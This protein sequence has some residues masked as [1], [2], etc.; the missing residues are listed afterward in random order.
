MKKVTFHFGPSVGLSNRALVV[1][2]HARAGDDS[3]P[4]SAT[5]ARDVGTVES[6]VV[7]LADNVLYQAVLTDYK[8]TGESSVPDILN[9]NTGS[10]QFPGPKTGDRLSVYAM[11]DLSSSS[12]AS[13]SSQSSSTSSAS[14]ASES[15]SSSSSPSMS[16]SSSSHS[17]STSSS[18]PSSYS[19]STSSSSPSSTSSSSVS[20]T[21]SS[22]IDEM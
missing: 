13:S 10:L 2:R 16:D 3:L 9:F 8:S 1:T 11:E 14:S 15:T 12:S 5:F 20:T 17:N 4:L 22:F 7:T 6:Y 19:K 18:S 21:S